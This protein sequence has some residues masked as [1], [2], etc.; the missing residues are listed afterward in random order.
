MRCILWQRVVA[1]LTFCFSLSLFTVSLAEAPATPAAGTCFSTGWPQDKSDLI[2]DS[3]LVFGTL[4]NGLRYVLKQNKEPQHRVALYLDVQSGSLHEQENQRGLAHFLEHMLF[5]G[6]T[7]YPPG[8]L[9]EYFQSL[10]MGFGNDT[11]AHTG[12]D[13]TVY[14]L[15]LP[16]ND[17]KAFTDGFQVLADYARGALLLEQEVNRERGVILA[18]K[19]S[20]DSA[21]AR[22]SKKQLQFDFAGTLV[23]K[24]EPIGLESVINAADSHLLR[25]YYDRWYQPGNMIV[26]VV[27]DFQPQAVEPLL[28][29]ALGN[30]QGTGVSSACPHYGRVSEKGT[31]TLVYPEKDL[32]YTGLALTTVFNR[33]PVPDTLAQEKEQLRRYLALILLSNRLKQVEQRPGSPL[34]QSDA[35]GG[36][37]LGRYGYASVSGR[38]VGG[39]WQEGLKV[40]QTTLRQALA[41]GFS[42]EE[43]QRGKRILYATLEQAVQTAATRDSRELAREIIRKLNDDEV[44]L[45]PEQEMHLYGPMVDALTLDDVHQGLRQL[46][47]HPRRL[48][49]VTG[50]IPDALKSKG[51]EALVRAA[52][53]KNARSPLPAWVEAKKAPFPYL[54]PSDTPGKIVAQQTY[55]KIGVETYELAGNV[56]LNIKRTDFQANEV[57]I[58]A[59]LGQGNQGEPQPGMGMISQAVVGESGLGRLTKE[60]L[61][62]ALDGTNISLTFKVGPES[63]SFAGKSLS[64]EFPTLITLLYHYL[65]DPAFREDAYTRSR[66]SL[67]RMYRQMDT[68]VEGVAQVQGERF[69]AG[70]CPEYGMAAWSEISQVGL[71]QIRN[72][73]TPVFAKAPLEINVVGDID[74]QEALRVLSRV[75]GHETREAGQDHA[76]QPPRFP[77]GQEKRISVASTINKSMLMVAWKTGDFWDIGRTRRLNLLASIVEDRLRVKIRQEL[78]ATYSPEVVSMPSRGVAGFGLLQS[79]LVVAP[80][81]AQTLSQAIKK[82]AIELGTQGVTQDELH[83][84]LEPTLTSIKDLKRS[85]RYWM[86]SVLILSSRHPQQL[87]WPQSIM[88]DFSSIKADEVT[89]LAREYLQP[90]QAA[91]VVVHPQAV[92]SA[93]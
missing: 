62:A 40:L 10:G 55:P 93:K 3:S 29:K 90:D 82:V 68:T 8:T 57:L 52:Y 48:V 86:E 11:N 77:A 72:W 14:N 39:R 60:Q 47:W 9:V 1:V 45:S 59:Q 92:I 24:R 17:S 28:K 65:H 80:D 15:F 69:L 88:E 85:N 66:S 35:L 5:N 12:Y 4:P 89:A 51:A 6:S 16:T 84:A 20:R 2:P 31:A 43:L 46:W 76:V 23:A 36:V 64:K 19:R 53:I 67:E 13:E 54:Q 21:S 83:R 58:S 56:R 41:H 33:E 78:G 26:V 61:Q 38:A 50:R 74:P 91:V 37:F 22:V 44:I 75:F 71:N 18:E 25:S 87:Q 27:G 79:F 70:S 42:A 34:A 81:Q 63:F 73:L 32:G 30:L 49:E 7:H